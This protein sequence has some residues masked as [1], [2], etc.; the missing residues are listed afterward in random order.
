MTLRA[1]QLARP[2]PPRSPT[3]GRCRRRRIRCC[4]TSSGGIRAIGQQD[5]AFIADGVFAWLRRRRSLEALAQTTHPTKLAL[6]VTV[7]ELGHSVRELSPLLNEADARGSP[8]S[9]RASDPSSRPPS[10]PICP[11]GCGR[12]SAKRTAMTSD[13]VLARAWLAPA[14][15]DLRVNPLK[16]TRDAARAALAASGIEAAPTPYSPLGLRV[17]GTTAARR[18]PLVTDGALEVQD[19]SSQ[20][21]GY[22]VAP[23]R[24]EMVVDFC[25]GAGGKTLLL[26]ALMRSQGRLY[27]FDVAAKRLANLKPRLARSGLSNVHPQ[28]IAGE[29]DAKIKRL[30]RQ[31]RP[32]A[33]RRAVHRLRHAAAQSRSQMAASRIRRGRARAQAAG[34]PRRGGDAREA[35]RT[36]RLRDVQRAAGRERVDRRPLSRRASR[37]RARQ[38]RGGARARGRRARYR[39]DLA[40]SRIATAATASSPRSSSAPRKAARRLRRTLRTERVSAASNPVDFRAMLTSIDFGRI[41][42]ALA[43]P[44]GWIELGGRRLCFAA[45]WAIS[46]QCASTRGRAEVVRVGLG[47]VNRVIFPLVAAC[48]LVVAPAVFRH[49]QP[50]FFLRIALPLAIALALIRLLRVCAARNLRQRAMDADVRAGDLVFDLGVRRPVFPR[51]SCRTSAPSSTRCRFRSAAATSRCWRSARASLSSS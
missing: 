21:V 34:D 43:T 20:L 33:G 17:A 2:T 7:R 39:P 9:S 47:G 4:T 42:S 8:N 32:R 19:E 23:R 35:G 51:R 5:R 24:S 29:R 36:P 15:L 12:A 25:A 31:D 46:R 1:N 18:H 16:T 30:A 45:G 3:C 44:A 26:G 49:F 38:R 6:A 41:E 22:L 27:A 11:I 13:R 37:V 28:L 50:P 14:P 10:P 48:A 40:S